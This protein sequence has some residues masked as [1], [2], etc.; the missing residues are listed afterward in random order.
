[1][2]DKTK[3]KEDTSPVIE[4]FLRYKLVVQG[5]SPK[6]VEEY[7]IDLHTFFSYLIATRAGLSPSDDGFYDVSISGVDNDFVK[8]VT[9][10]DILEFLVY[11]A[12]E[13]GNSTASRARK[14]SALKTFFKYM[15][16]TEKIMEKNPAIDIETPKRKASLPKYL[17]ESESVSLLS[18]VLNDTES[19]T[20]ERDFC[21]ITL[22]LNCGMRLSELVG[23]NLSDIDREFRSMRVVG[24]GNKERIVYLYD[25]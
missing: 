14:L 12:N 11:T 19:R 9:T 5:R 4:R 24:K 23:I 22:F 1:M 20:K 10:L 18:S 15:V 3:V 17:S 16:A 2:S 13:R 25:A 7:R 21:I 8:S 6:T